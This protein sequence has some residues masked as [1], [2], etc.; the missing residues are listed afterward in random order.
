MS[1]RYFSHYTFIYPDKFYK[2]YIV[3]L[4][5]E[6]YITSLYTFSREVPN[7]IFQSGTI[8]F[9]PDH[10]ID[11]IDIKDLMSVEPRL[12]ILLSKDYLIRS[13]RV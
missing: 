4:D 2:N 9:L 3:E 7:T 10:L 13:F 5:A 12:E 8:V 1:Q 6:G 11:S